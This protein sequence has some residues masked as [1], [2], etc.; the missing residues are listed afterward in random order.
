MNARHSLYETITNDILE[1]LQKGIAP[2]VQPWENGGGA[3]PL[4]PY[5]AASGH[6]YRGVNVLLL[7]RASRVKGYRH[8]AWI[9]YHQA[10]ERGGYV[11][12]GEKA[13]VIVYARTY[14]LTGG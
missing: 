6:R 13:T 3:L 2:W 11:K 4:L 8:P 5:N 12:K 9:G 10:H 14:A 7:W 1:E